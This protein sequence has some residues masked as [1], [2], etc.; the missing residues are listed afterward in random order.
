MFHLAQ[1]FRTFS[2]LAN[3]SKL[4]QIDCPSGIFLLKNS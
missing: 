4:I 1:P 2:H 3:T